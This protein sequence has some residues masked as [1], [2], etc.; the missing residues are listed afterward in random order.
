[1]KA[2]AIDELVSLPE[3]LAVQRH[4]DA[5]NYRFFRW[6]LGWNLFMALPA[7]GTAL[8]KGW[9]VSL[10]FFLAGLLLT[11]GLIAARQT[12]F[13]ETYFRQVLLAYLF[14]CILLLKVV[15]LHAEDPGGRVPVFFVAGFVLLFFRLRLSEQLMLYGSAWM[16]AI[17]PLDSRGWPSG[18]EFPEIG[19]VAALTTM[20][21]VCLV[22][23]FVLTQ[24]EKR[25]FLSVWRREHSRAKERARMREEIDT[26]RRIQVSMLPQGPPPDLR[27]LD[28]AAASLPA[29][30][31]G[32]DYF[33]YF[34]LS[35]NQLALVIG[36]V[37][38]HG[39]A[40]GLVLSGV[41]SCL[42]LLESALAAP[43][44]ILDR[45]NPMVRRTT[46]RRTFVTLLC[47]VL[48][49]NGTGG[50]LIL[51]SAGHPPALRWCARTR[52]TE[53]VGE[54]APP[55]GTFLDAHYQE[56]S[57][58]LERGDLL[59]FYTDGLLE[60]RNSADVEYG[61]TRLQ[62]AVS[63]LAGSASARE[64]RDAILGDLSNFK[65][66]VEQ[67]DDITVVAVRMR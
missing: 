33:D 47:A 61:D 26:A 18:A 37:A 7:I 13:Y 50:R 63:R 34:R 3:A 46:D 10:G 67:S 43:V 17:L 14:I 28:V 66:D 62:R 27:W 40:S 19:E 54:G 38:G 60:A 30:E 65:G 29:T 1:M 49:N 56:V 32:G 21:G 58:P 57:R 52:E 20:L 31:V 53:F 42:Y 22:F 55:L 35:P 64:V 44:E 11:M 4:F 51:A 45:L 12:H 16:A 41:R 59:V 23:A 48:E 15:S 2:P 8:S 9:F 25:R 6:L 39:V 36:D 5:R 24:L